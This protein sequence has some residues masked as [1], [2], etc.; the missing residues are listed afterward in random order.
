MFVGNKTVNKPEEQT[1]VNTSTGKTQWRLTAEFKNNGLC[2]LMM[3]PR[4]DN[5]VNKV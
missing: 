5:A 3:N 2:D 1:G 4:P